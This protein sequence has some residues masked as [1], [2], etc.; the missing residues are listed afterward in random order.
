MQVRE[1]QEIVK[2]T[3]VYPKE[4][5]LAYCGLGLTGEAGEVAEKIKKLY[6]DKPEILVHFESNPPAVISLG[7]ALKVDTF[8]REVTKEIGDVIWYCTALA[9][10]IGVTLEEVMQTNYNKLISRRKTNTLHGSGDDREELINDP[11]DMQH[12]GI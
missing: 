10:E 8:K 11:D 5:G 4:I 2:K 3:A 7:D 12:A 6:R 1:Y 9:S